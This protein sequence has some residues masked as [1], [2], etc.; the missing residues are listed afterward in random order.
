ML[1]K[2]EVPAGHKTIFQPPALRRTGLVENCHRKRSKIRRH[3]ISIDEQ[4]HQRCRHDHPSQAAIAADLN[5]FLT[6]D[7]EDPLH[8]PNL[9]WNRRAAITSVVK[10]KTRMYRVSFQKYSMP[11]PF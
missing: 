10:P 11:S 4:L 2:S 7:P 8:Q 5:K 3:D 1:L 6:D 9:F